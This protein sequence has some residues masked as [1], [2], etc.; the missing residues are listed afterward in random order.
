MISIKAEL[1]KATILNLIEAKIDQ[2]CTGE[3]QE[4]NKMHLQVR[5]F[6]PMKMDFLKDNFSFNLPLEVKLIKGEGI[7]TVTV[8]GK[9]E[10]LMNLEYSINENA[11]FQ[12]RTVLK[13]HYWIEGPCLEIG[14]L[15]IPIER[16]ADI[17]ISYH[18]DDLLEIVNKQVQDSMN[19]LLVYISEPERLTNA[20]IPYIPKDLVLLLGVNEIIMESPTNHDGNIT[21]K[22]LIKPN[23]ILYSNDIVVQPNVKS[24]AFK[25]LEKINDQTLGYLKFSFSYEYI[26]ERLKGSLS[27]LEIGG[28]KLSINNLQIKK[29]SNQVVIKGR[30]SSPIEGSIELRGN[31]YFNESKGEIAI[32]NFHCSVNPDSFLFKLGAPLINKV[33][34]ERIET[35]LP[36]NINNYI[37]NTLKNKVQQSRTF[38]NVQVL[39]DLGHFTVDEML[40]NPTTIDIKL[41]YENLKVDIKTNAL[42]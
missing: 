21:L 32:N 20:L 16:V 31:L 18:K 9:I 6:N 10:L 37:N 17:V 7:F 4:I 22:S 23:A 15:D 41:R 34:S 36:F 38:S 24:V 13:D 28:K 19:G 40:F 5:R 42:S 35:I 25:W 14:S 3:M 30:L 2:V 12:S 33:V 1:Q 29:E 11:V 39:I 26:K 27:N 8:T